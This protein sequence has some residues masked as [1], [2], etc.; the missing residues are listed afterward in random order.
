[1]VVQTACKF[2]LLEMSSNVLVGHLLHAGLKKVG[3]LAM[4]DWVFGY[5][6][7][8][9]VPLPRTRTCF[10]P[11]TSCEIEGWRCQR[12]IASSSRE[13]ERGPGAGGEAL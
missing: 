4:L 12:G 3:F 1:V 7:L 13:E 11:P 8:S 9:V 5:S 2:G 10:H 6:K